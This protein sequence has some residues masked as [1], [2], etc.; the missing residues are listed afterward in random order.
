MTG[1]QPLLSDVLHGEIVLS[2]HL[3]SPRLRLSSQHQD[4]LGGEDR[5]VALLKPHSHLDVPTVP[6]RLRGNRLPPS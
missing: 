4:V 5:D 1:V 2:D 3:G 6:L